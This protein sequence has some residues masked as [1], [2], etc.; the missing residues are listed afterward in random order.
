MPAAIPPA[1]RG[2]GWSDAR[3]FAATQ[4]RKNPNSYFYRHVAPHQVQVRQQ[5]HQGRVGTQGPQHMTALRAM[6]PAASRRQLSVLPL[7]C[8]LDGQTAH[9]GACSKAA[10]CCIMQTF[11]CAGLCC[12][13][14]YCITHPDMW[15]LHFGHL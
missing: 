12:R 6:Q 5:P 2:K 4:L 15:H 3:A 14:T 1:L 10:P 11:Y 7:Q 13:N 8:A 9:D